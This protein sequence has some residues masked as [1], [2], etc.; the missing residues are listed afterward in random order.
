MY[1]TSIHSNLFFLVWSSLVCSMALWMTL[2]PGFQALHPVYIY[3][4]CFKIMVGTLIK[5]GGMKARE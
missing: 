2:H 1:D 5:L 3:T 4:Y